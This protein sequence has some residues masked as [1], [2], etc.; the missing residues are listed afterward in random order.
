[1]D[2]TLSPEIEQF[3]TDALKSGRF[4]S[5]TEVV[6]EGLRLLREQEEEDLSRTEELRAL[7]AEGIADAD[8]GLYS[9]FDEETLREIQSEGRE[10]LAAERRPKAS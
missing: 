10:R 9:T 1:M 4:R 8:Q 6:L 5:P 2:I 7:I 3:V